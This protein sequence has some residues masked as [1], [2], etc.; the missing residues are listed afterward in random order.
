MAK[1]SKHI[2][3]WPH[4]AIWVG[5]G[6]A[7]WASLYLRAPIPPQDPP[8][9]PPTS[10][11]SVS[12][13]ATP[14]L[15]YSTSAEVEPEALP[16]ATVSEPVVLYDRRPKLGEKIGTITLKSL[17]LSWPVFEGTE[18]AQLA[19]GVGHYRKSVLPGVED[20]TILSGHRSTVFNR[21]GELN[22][23]DL[24]YV[25]TKAGVFTYQVRGFRVVDRSDRTVIMPTETAVM[26]LTTCYPFNH[27]GIT[28]D[29]FIVTADLIE[30][31]LSTAPAK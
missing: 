7:L 29:A 5:I 13:H 18:D 26:T 16:V 23:G 4:L 1:H 9:V 27:I 8:V 2:R 17:D 25:K 10:S 28:T 24:I 30:S 12:A 11:A 6:L 22:K 31:V 19:K 3:H 15:E 14:S 21:L 20:N